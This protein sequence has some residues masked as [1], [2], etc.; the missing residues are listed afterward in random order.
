MTLLEV[1]NQTMMILML[2]VV[3]RLD[4]STRTAPA[5]VRYSASI[6]GTPP[7]T[8]L[9]TGWL[10]ECFSF[11]MAPFSRGMLILVG[12]PDI[13]GD[14]DTGT[15]LLPLRLVALNSDEGLTCGNLR[16]KQ[17]HV[18]SKA[19]LITDITGLFTGNIW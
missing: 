1:Q 9:K 15:V 7:K 8:N 17:P 3:E 18:S 10:E 19:S 13:F 12:V 16:G 14:M 6:L 4:A 5:Y 11:E 2:L